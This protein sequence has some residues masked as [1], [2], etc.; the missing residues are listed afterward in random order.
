MSKHGLARSELVWQGG[1]NEVV[2]T[3][4]ST[5]SENRVFSI[6]GAF[7]CVRSAA[8]WAQKMR[9]VNAHLMHQPPVAGEAGKVLFMGVN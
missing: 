9:A 4:V 5:L 6:F 8:A 3:D 1:E 7:V 2:K